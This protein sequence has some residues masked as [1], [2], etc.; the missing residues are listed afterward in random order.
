MAH[1][2]LHAL[3]FVCVCVCGS[4]FLLQALSEASD[5]EA[6]RQ[7]KRAIQLEEKRL[8]ALLDLE[9]A[10]QHRKADL[11]VRCACDVPTAVLGWVGFVTSHE[12]ATPRCSLH[13]RA[14]VRCCV[15]MALPWWR[16]AR[17]FSTGCPTS[18]ATQE[19]CEV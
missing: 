4:L 5:L 13:Q 2:F 14:W 7:E 1:A 10:G 16:G 19:V 6:L 15:L 3:M 12:H 9:K 8:K 18:G 17:C 11:L